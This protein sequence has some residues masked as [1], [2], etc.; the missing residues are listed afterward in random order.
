MPSW[1]KVITSGSDAHLK[2]INTDGNISGSSVSTGSFGRTEGTSFSYV[3]DS[4]G[5]FVYQNDELIYKNGGNEKLKVDNSQLTTEVVNTGRVK[6]GGENKVQLDETSVSFVISQNDGGM[7]DTLILTKEGNLELPLG[8]MSGSSVSTGS[9]GRVET[10]VISGLSPLV[11]EADNV[12]VD[13]DGSVSGS[14]TSTGSFGNLRVGT[15][16]IQIPNNG[17]LTMGSEEGMVKN[18]R[19]GVNAGNSLQSGGT[20]NVLVGEE[21]GAALTTGDKNVVMGVEALK[22]ET[23]GQNNTAIGY[24]SLKTLN[25]NSV[26]GNVALGLG[27][28][29]DLATGAFNILIGYSPETQ[30]ND[31]TRSIVIG[32]EDTVGLGS[33]TTVIGGSSQTL[34]AFGGPA[35]ISGSSASTGS[36][37]KVF[38]DSGEIVT[39]GDMTLDADGA[40]ILLSDGGTEFGRFKRDT[41]DFIIKSAGNNNDIIF[42][43]VD[44][45]STITALTLDMSEEGDAYFNNDISG[46]T[47]RASGDII[48]FNSSDERLKDNVEP[49]KFPLDKLGKIGGYTF[50]WND[51]QQVYHGH[52][53][54]VLAQEIEEVIPE[55]VKDRGNGY[56]GVQYDKIIP[57]L[58]EGIK[59]LK[60]KVK[61]IEENCDCLKK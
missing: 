39:T 10:S 6:I 34:V 37:G 47:V 35:L 38:V 60:E 25:Q 36:F 51:K 17:I 3:F 55:A 48:A 32:S 29:E 1:K 8:N 53:I 45:T 24:R 7:Q 22:T 33:N 30:A 28:G 41:S 19:F 18:T 61:H 23:G 12:N 21:A 46:S 50:D 2:T 44:N 49:I 31:D 9:F 43:G 4:Q 26:G 52:D 16:T 14:S 11:I 59:E 54:G 20:Q 57:L 58:I 27:A 13:S 56:K 5:S 15:A 42:K 40:D